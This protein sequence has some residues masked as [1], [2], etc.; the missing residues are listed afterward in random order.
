MLR[1]WCVA[2]LVKE[3][4]IKG[5]EEEKKIGGIIRDDWFSGEMQFLFEEEDGEKRHALLKSKL[6]FDYFFPRFFRG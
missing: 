1:G 6:I 2:G 4:K 3:K 5:D